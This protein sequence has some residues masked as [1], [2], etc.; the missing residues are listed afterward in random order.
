MIMVDLVGAGM[1]PGNPK[2]AWNRKNE[3][4]YLKFT[5]SGKL[6]DLAAAEAIE[7]WKTAFHSKSGDKIILIWD[8][9]D[10]DGFDYEA[11]QKWQHAMNE[12]KPQ[13]NEI[14]LITNSKLF[15]VSAKVMGVL[16]SIPIHVV[17]AETKIM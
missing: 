12:L 3:K 5:F 16:T 2:I 4:M 1:N 17:D 6:T 11:R 15:L 8:C 13:I 10:M 9:L 7:Q 14:W